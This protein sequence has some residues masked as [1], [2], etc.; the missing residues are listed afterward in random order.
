MDMDRNTSTSRSR[1]KS[2]TCDCGSSPELLT[3]WWMEEHSSSSGNVAIGG[4]MMMGGE[5]LNGSRI[6]FPLS[7]T[8]TLAGSTRP[9]WSHILYSD[10]ASSTSPHGTRGRGRGAILGNASHSQQLNYA[11][12]IGGNIYELGMPAVS[13]TDHSHAAGSNSETGKEMNIFDQISGAVSFRARTPRNT[14]SQGTTDTPW[15]SSCSGSMFAILTASLLS[16]AIAFHSDPLQ[17]SNKYSNVPIPSASNPPAMIVH[18]ERSQLS[19]SLQRSSSPVIVSR[20][21]S[22][23]TTTNPG[24]AGSAGAI[25]VTDLSIGAQRARQ[26]LRVERDKTTIV[27]IQDRLKMD[28]QKLAE[29][30]IEE[31]RNQG[32]KP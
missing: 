26:E 12:A 18:V 3:N 20:G 13:S 15:L 22:T 6:W 25:E 32:L 1:S 21:S 30:R 17:H 31:L 16:A 28:E 8:G 2:K 27:R 23:A 11:E 10:A 14:L 19:S 24:S 4:A 7:Q 5:L 9:S 29:L